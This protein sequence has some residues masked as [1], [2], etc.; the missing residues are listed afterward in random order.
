MKYKELEKQIQNLNNAYDEQ[1]KVTNN[2]KSVYIDGANKCYAII[3]NQVP[4]SLYI[5]NV[6]FENLEDNLRHDLLKAVYEFAQTPIDERNLFPKYYISSKLTPTVI[7]KFLFKFG[8]NIDHLGWGVKHGGGTK[9]TQNEI[10]Y[11]CDKFHTDLKDFE[12]IEVEE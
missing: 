10:D 4:Y 8:E 11:I 9:F 12:I 7:E 1:L 6:A 2:G 3:T 5:S